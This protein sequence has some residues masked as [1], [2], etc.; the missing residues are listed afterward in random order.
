MKYTKVVKAGHALGGLGG[1]VG[2]RMMGHGWQGRDA[3]R[4]ALGANAGRERASGDAV[5]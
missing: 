4:R 1:A 3:G 5:A 2:R